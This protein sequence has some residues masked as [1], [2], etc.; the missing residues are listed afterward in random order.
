ML[1]KTQD[2]SAFITFSSS[3]AWSN[4]NVSSFSPSDCFI[5]TWYNFDFPLRVRESIFQNQIKRYRYP[6]LYFGI[7]PPTVHCVIAIPNPRGA[8]PSSVMELGTMLSK[9]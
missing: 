5:L 9:L 2:D 3:F 7:F 4:P 6:T 1:F 8:I